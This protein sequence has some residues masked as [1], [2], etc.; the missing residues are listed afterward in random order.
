MRLRPLIRPSTRDCWSRCTQ[1]PRV[2]F[3]GTW[4]ENRSRN[5]CTPRSLPPE[6]LQRLSMSSTQSKQ[7]CP[8]NVRAMKERSRQAGCS[9]CVL[10]LETR[11]TADMASREIERVGRPSASK[12]EL[13]GARIS[14][15]KWLPSKRATPAIPG[16]VLWPTSAILIE[17]SDDRD[18]PACTKKRTLSTSIC[19]VQRFQ[20]AMAPK[21]RARY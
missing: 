19:R 15:P 10:P 14:N 2:P 16:S 17:L 4:Q 9:L 12:Q 18:G 11:K 5:D 6:N 3:L 7:Y 20:S 21:H 13:S 1:Y 8:C